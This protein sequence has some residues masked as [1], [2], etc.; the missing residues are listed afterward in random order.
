MSGVGAYLLITLYVYDLKNPTLSSLISEIKPGGTCKIRVLRGFLK[1]ECTDTSNLTYFKCSQDDGQYQVEYLPEKEFDCSEGE[2]MMKFDKICEKDTGFYQICGHQRCENDIQKDREG[3]LCGEFTCKT[4]NLWNPIDNERVTCNEKQDCPNTEIDE[5]MCDFD[6]RVNSPWKKEFVPESVL[7]DDKCDCSNCADESLLGNNRCESENPIGMFCNKTLKLYFFGHV[8]KTIVKEVYIEPRMVCDKIMHCDN[9][10]DE[11]NCEE[12]NEESCNF[13]NVYTKPELFG[14][15]VMDGVLQKRPLVP[16]HKCSVPNFRNS[17]VKLV[18][19]NF[20]DQM[21]CSDKT[22]IGLKCLNRNG[23]KSISLS[24]Y[25]VDCK[26]RQRIDGSIRKNSNT[27]I[28]DTRSL[29]P[30]CMDSIDAKCHNL[31]YGC[32]VHK[33]K[34]CDNR[35]D[36]PLTRRDEIDDICNDMETVNCTRRVGGIKWSIPSKW[37][38][39]GVKDCEDGEDENKEFWEK[40]RENYTVCGGKNDWSSVKSDN[41]SNE[42]FYFC[43]NTTR[44]KVNYKKLCDRIPSCGS[45]ERVCRVARNQDI[46]QTKTNFD[47]RNFNYQKARIS[48]C[49]QGLENQAFLDNGCKEINITTSHNRDKVFGVIQD[50]AILPNKS[51]NCNFLFGVH[52]VMATCNNNCADNNTSCK[53]T[54]LKYDSCAGEIAEKNKV[55]SVAT[56]KHG[57]P[58]LTLVKMVGSHFKTQ[59]LF[60]CTSGTCISFDK[61][62]NLANDCGDWSDEL[63][64]SNQFSCN[65]TE[66]RI[67]WNKHCDGIFDCADYSDECGDGC[68]NSKEVIAGT[69]LVGCSWTLGLLATFLNLITVTS[70]SFQIFRE[71]SMVK[72]SNLAMVVFIGLGD[73]CVGLY[74]VGISIVNYQYQHGDS[75]F[76]QD[77][78]KW[79]TSDACSAL[80][81]LNTFGSQLSLY[82]MTLLSILRVFCIKTSSLRGSMTWKG[83][84]VIVLV[85]LSM[86]LVAATIAFIPLLPQLEDYFVNGLAYFDNPMLI[87]SHDKYKHIAILREHYGKFKVQSL[88][89]KQIMNMV[90]D[91]FSRF[92]N[93][94]VI[95]SKVNFYGN[96]G[97]CL[98]KFFVRENDPQKLYTWFVIIQNALCFL[99]ITISY[100]IVYITV[101]E[102]TRRVSQAT[103]RKASTASVSQV[104]QPKRNNTLNRKIT[105]MVL[106]DFLCWVPF[107]VV[108]SLHYLDAI[109]ATDLYSIFSI[110][111]LP[112]NSVINPL[113]YDNNGIIDYV[114]KSCTK[115]SNYVCNTNINKYSQRGA[116]VASQ[117]TQLGITEVPTQKLNADIVELED[118]ASTS[119]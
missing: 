114:Q 15:V 105:L 102:S 26:T 33:H 91:M 103:M 6:C 64:C 14:P 89:W 10:A 45:E 59:Q 83:K 119:K 25:L 97:V 66:D 80:G 115:L 96:S 116:T 62:C 12:E 108:C 84:T 53:L 7:C 54:K 28:N 88:S 30:F 99:A 118:M 58:Y 107:I 42:K 67:P 57:K 21:N 72:I 8:Y 104:K 13:Y 36:C 16:I 51:M 39:D 81:I 74:L 86:V 35:T 113:L 1:L 71:D 4:E 18:C 87:G 100:L 2:N 101:E 75:T 98:F 69:F 5:S 77:Y 94:P 109:D 90:A 44:E 92:A 24:K 85:C 34:M 111:I 32:I 76:C 79:L 9:E 117:G 95:G 22:K 73:L 60:E 63:D 19:N 70:T 31:G 37:V 29:K 110:I 68:R 27:L 43:S 38:E 23:S 65:G 17:D 46:L 106:T 52:Y 78:Y 48:Y 82:S 11:L 41:C 93:S 55:Y 49:H 3:M 40:R 61:V 20:S 56:P 112:L 47:S 50:V